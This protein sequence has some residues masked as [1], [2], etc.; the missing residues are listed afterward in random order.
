MLELGPIT[1]VTVNV[2]LTRNESPLVSIG[3]QLGLDQVEMSSE[4]RSIR[5]GEFV[6]DGQNFLFTK[7]G[8]AVPLTPKALN[9]LMVLIENRSR[10]VSKGELIEKVWSDS[11][12]E[13]GNL[14][15]TIRLIRK[16]LNDDASTP[17]YI[18]SVPR[19]GYR[20]ISSVETSHD[21]APDLFSLDSLTDEDPPFI[22]RSREI[23]E[24]S[25]LLAD[26]RTRLV[27]LTGTGGAG[28]TRLSR[29]VGRLSKEYFDG[30][31]FFIDLS[32]VSDA[33][34][35]PTVIAQSLGLREAGRRTAGEALAKHFGA[36]SS[37]LILDNFEQVVSAA[38]D[39][40]QLLR[41]APSLKILITSREPLKLKTE[42]EF[43]VPPLSMPSSKTVETSLN[44]ARYEAI[45][46]FIERAR[47]ARPDF[48]L[49][50]DELRTITTI[51]HRLDGLPLAIEL[52]AARAKI[53][54]ASEI[55]AKLEHGLSLLTGGSRD[56]PDRQQTMR[57]T[58]T[59]SFDLLAEIEKAV[60]KRLA[61][62][63]GGFTYDAAESVLSGSDAPE[64]IVLLDA[65]TSLVDKGLLAADR[66]D[67]KPRFRMLV[68]VREFAFE[69]LTESGALESIARSHAEY[70]TDLAEK[71]EPKLQTPEVGPWVRRL[72][73]EHDNLRTAIRWS[74]GVD[75]TY[76]ARIAKALR[77]FW[78]LRGYT[79]EA[80][81]WFSEV[82]KAPAIP[83]E[84]RAIL[85]TG[86]ANMTQFRGDFAA[87]ETVYRESLE[88]SRATG[89]PERIAQA[90]RGVAGV[91]YMRGDA[92]TAK[93]IVL[94]A[95]SISRGADDNFG[96]AAALA[97]L[98]DIA[99]V[100]GDAE[101][102]CR[103]AHEA[104]EIFLELGFG[105]GIASKLLNLGIAEVAV[106]AIDA[107]RDHLCESLEKA[108]EIG[109]Y[110]T[111]RLALEGLSFVSFE[112]GDHFNSARL[113]AAATR[114][115]DEID[116]LL[117]PAEMKMRTIYIHQ[118]KEAMGEARFT[119]AFSQGLNMDRTEAVD[120][121]LGA[122]D[123]KEPK[124]R[125]V[126]KSARGVRIRPD[127]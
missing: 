4:S 93:E 44:L 73:L 126:K 45:E 102:A 56:L 119:D 10:V 72:E 29:E 78:M 18:E 46:F 30:G 40:A 66:S 33:T 14:A 110:I 62:F 51:C 35:V 67:G 61:V 23:S 88:E 115:G 32:A 116:H 2:A 20:F 59:W 95:L 13:E 86:L 87:A 127:R 125:V 105:P 74:I 77:L 83:S 43:K 89:D 113:S 54:S 64:N 100:Q 3:F 9:L 19:R 15:Y 63:E 82:L 22:G 91:I 57:A 47:H 24:I 79:R 27:T 55:L 6:L 28:K 41:S 97:R 37:L 25:G 71:A 69:L 107:A 92:A 106:G 48:G 70:F 104:L 16:A 112:A 90:M 103:R 38:P 50:D 68:V 49:S 39:I 109:D 52:A 85:L 1:G 53:L 75:A 26:D 65:I 111:T 122:S 98:G 121:A 5:F 84:S 81:Y 118:L 80:Q 42:T 60:F 76:A 117:E 101:G 36:R 58:I 34:L 94:E 21:D 120:L 96:T 99:L 108:V 12:V 8:E 123:E 124:L 7:S 17:T 11:F 31:V 114:M